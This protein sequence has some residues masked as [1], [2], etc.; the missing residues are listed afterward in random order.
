MN[1]AGFFIAGADW[2]DTKGNENETDNRGFEAALPRR[3]LPT[4]ARG[5]VRHVLAATGRALGAIGRVRNGT[6]G[7]TR[8]R[9][10][11]RHAD[12]ARCKR[13]GP[14]VMDPHAC[15]CGQWKTAISSAVRGTPNRQC[16]I[17]A[18]R[19][20]S[21]GGLESWRSGG[22]TRRARGESRPGQGLR[23]SCG[24]VSRI[25]QSR[26]YCLSDDF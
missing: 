12:R 3:G 9:F 7:R 13:C 10:A 14:K 24:R 8:A 2:N 17:A 1:G 26:A 16:G 20:C 6:A 18:A 21:P 15:D 4:L 5:P 23:P 19:E 22:A 11:A 25:R